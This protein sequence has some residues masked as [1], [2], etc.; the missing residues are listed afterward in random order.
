MRRNLP[1]PPAPPKL[2]GVLF[3][4]IPLGVGLTV[5]I[6]LWSK[7]FDDW[8]SPP[9][10]FRVFGSFIAL[11]FLLFGGFAARTFSAAAK[12]LSSMELIDRQISQ[13]QDASSSQPPAAP[14][15]YACPDCGASLDPKAEV[16]PL[17]DVKCGYCGSWFNIHGRSA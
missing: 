16:S 13:A 15:R 12:G 4:I 14:G 3:S 17:G 10:V 2:F 9:L 7:P 8:D 6:F 1:Q 11:G 5:L